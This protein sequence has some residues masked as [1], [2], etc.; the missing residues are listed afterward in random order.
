MNRDMIRRFAQSY[1]VKP[2][3]ISRLPYDLR[4]ET[5]FFMTIFTN[6]S[7]YVLHY[8]RRWYPPMQTLPIL[9]Y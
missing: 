4:T 5:Y 9:V 8:I 3:E 7:N 6:P 1:M 2:T